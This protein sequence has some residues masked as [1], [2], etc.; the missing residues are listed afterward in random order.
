MSGNDRV[1]RQW[2]PR[3]QSA[4][5]LSV[6]RGIY[7][8]IALGS[9]LAVLGGLVYVGYLLAT[10]AGQPETVPIPPSYQG[11]ETPLSPSDR[12]LDLAVVGQ[13]FEPPTNVRFQVASSTWTVPPKAGQ[14]LGYFLADTP[15]GLASF[16]EGVSVIGGRDAELFERVPDG[17]SK[18]NSLAARAALVAQ[19]AEALQVIQEPTNRTFE[20]RVVARDQYGT[21]SAPMDLAFDL[22][23]APKP[24]A[25]ATA[26]PSAPP[27]Q[28][29]A[30]EAVASE[31]ARIVEPEVNPAHFAAYRTALKAPSRCGASDSDG[32]FIADYRRALEEV[33]PRLTSTNVEALYAGLCDARKEL[34]KREAAAQERVEQQQRAAQRAA[35]EARER[36]QAQNNE[37]QRRHAAQVNEAK[38]RT[39]QTMAV[40]GGALV[41]F[42]SVALVLAFLAIEGHSRAVRAAMEAMVQMAQGRASHEPAADK[43]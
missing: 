41:L 7:L 31:V 26:P 32:P 38:E 14:V 21:A 13:R 8:V 23:F 10:I 25:S 34:L 20:I 35:E 43:G 3:L 4:Y 39:Q 2:F 29:T 28:P 42:L 30:L 5:V 6:A 17:A 15:N 18:K 40:V 16:P 33:R 1:G 22:R 37:L 12:T 19:V 27:A 11:T 24:A 36:A 9:L